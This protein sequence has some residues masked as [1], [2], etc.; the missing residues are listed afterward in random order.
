MKTIREKWIPSLII[1]LLLGS[2]GLGLIYL[3]INDKVSVIIATTIVLISLVV[4]L[5]VYRPLRRALALSLTRAELAEGGQEKKTTDFSHEL[6]KALG[7]PA[8]KEDAVLSG[9]VRVHASYRDCEA[10]VV[11]LI[12]KA[13]TVRVLSNTGQTD[14]GKGTR[15]YDALTIN[16]QARVE[17]LIAALDSPFISAEWAETHGFSPD[18]A[19]N[20]SA[21]VLQSMDDS[22]QLKE[23]HHVD[24]SL[25]G[26]VL[27]FVW[28]VWIIDQTAFVSAWL[29]RT[30][31]VDVAQVVEL[32]APPAGSAPNLFDMFSKYFDKVWGE[33]SQAL[34]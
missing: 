29:E 26:H 6:A 34:F 20:W 30:K 14:I 17:V 9:V 28:H 27:P 12:K 25:R 15:F 31:N 2:L 24:I 13:Q 23:Y 16:Q 5:L 32:H 11:E 21:R 18:K 19:K 33:Q 3:G 10:R 8:G 1:S 22:R 4:L 7:N